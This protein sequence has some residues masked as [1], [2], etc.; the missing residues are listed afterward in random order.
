MKIY[1]LSLFHIS[2]RCTNSHIYINLI[3]RHYLFLA[4]KLLWES[5]QTVSESSTLKQSIENFGVMWK[6]FLLFLSLLH[7]SFVGGSDVCPVT[8]SGTGLFFGGIMELGD[9]SPEYCLTEC[10]NQGLVAKGA[11]MPL[12]GIANATFCF[13][14][15]EKERGEIKCLL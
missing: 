11:Q 3:H 7:F 10:Q 2:E 9:Q 4:V 5:Q 15:L 14:G 12:I 13:C 6:I 8:E 1:E